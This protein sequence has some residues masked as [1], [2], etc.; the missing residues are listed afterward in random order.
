MGDKAAHLTCYWRGGSQL[1]LGLHA[2][3]CVV[4][5]VFGCRHLLAGMSLLAVLRSSSEQFVVWVGLMIGVSVQGRHM[6]CLF[7]VMGLDI[8]RA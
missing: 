7:A 2:T 5:A 6:S 4:K 3:F 1:A 8:R